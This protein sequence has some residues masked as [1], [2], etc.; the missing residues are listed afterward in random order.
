[1]S[2]HSWNCFTQAG[3]PRRAPALAS[4]LSAKLAGTG[5]RGRA[6]DP[7][8]AGKRQPGSG[9]GSLP[10]GPGDAV[11][12]AGHRKI[13]KSSPRGEASAS[14]AMTK[15]TRVGFRFSC[16]LGSLVRTQRYNVKSPTVT[17]GCFKNNFSPALQSI[18]RPRAGLAQ[19]WQAPLGSPQ[20]AGQQTERR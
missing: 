8:T 18:F 9:P 19:L 3:R 20:A 16:C 6:A 5:P 10:A 14:L 12:K 2:G 1:M 17:T 11:S 7:G 15:R 4:S 13:S